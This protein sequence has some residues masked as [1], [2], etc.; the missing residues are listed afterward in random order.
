MAART[1]F[2]GSCGAPNPAGTTYCGRCGRPLA[3]PATAPLPAPAAHAYP[4]A[5]ATSQQYAAAVP[6]KTHLWI[7]LIAAAGVGLFMLCLAAVA[8]LIEDRPPPNPTCP[9]SC[10]PP[11]PRLAPPL[12]PQHT[13]SS[14]KYGWSLAYADK[15]QGI[16]LTIAGQTE[17]GIQFKVGSFPIGFDAEPAKGR[18]PQ[19][20]AEGLQQKTL[21]QATFVYALPAA[22]M[23]YNPGYGAVYD[24]TV[25][26]ASGQSLHVRMIIEVAVKK[27]LAIELVEV[28]PFVQTTPK[29]GF[30]NPSDTILVFLSSGIVNTVTFPGDPVL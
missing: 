30:P 15:V 18:T 21:P 28:G 17:T 22:E 27:D 16:S 19:Q 9:P 25:Q 20:I 6:A 13:F 23:G 5:P 12:G 3:A 24:T 1:V 26:T 29:D 7:W 4:Y 11:P 2:C 14:T 8:V 10:A